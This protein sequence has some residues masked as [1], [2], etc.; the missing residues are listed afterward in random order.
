MVRF[1]LEENDK[2]DIHYHRYSTH[3]HILQINK[4]VSGDMSKREKVTKNETG[5]PHKKSARTCESGDKSENPKNQNC[6]ESDDSEPLLLPSSGLVNLDSQSSE[7][8]NCM[9]IDDGIDLQ[10]VIND[11]DNYDEAATT[12]LGISSTKNL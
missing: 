9:L 12:I 8:Q 6:S 2:N 5:Q 1:I 4:F 10:T 11:L 3:F 7:D